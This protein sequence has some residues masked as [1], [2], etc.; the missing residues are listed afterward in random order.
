V[1]LK[2]DSVKIKSLYCVW[3][4]S[5]PLNVYNINSVSSVHIFSHIWL[6]SIWMHWRLGLYTCK[7]KI[8]QLFSLLWKVVHIVGRPYITRFS[9][10]F[11]FLFWFIFS[12][13]FQFLKIERGLWDH[14]AVCVY[15]PIVARQRLSKHVPVAKNTHTTM[16]ELLDTVFSMRSVSF[17][18]ICREKNVDDYNKWLTD[19]R[20]DSDKRQ[21]R[22]LVREGAPQKNKTVCMYVCKGWAINRAPHC[23]LQWS[24]VLP[25]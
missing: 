3:F 16:S 2:F 18:I 25:L 10:Q 20:N 23:D 1:T 24:I 7:T 9:K 5:R 15:P 12:L 6:K 19:A 11:I 13:I 8:C 14:L 21:T 22:P 17:E 4:W